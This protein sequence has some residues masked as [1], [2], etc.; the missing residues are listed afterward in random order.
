MCEVKGK[1]RSGQAEGKSHQNSHWMDKTI[2]LR[3][4]NHIGH[5][6]PESER[7]EKIFECLLKC[8][9]ASGDDKLL[10]SSESFFGDFSDGIDGLLL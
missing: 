5:D 8:L 3:G 4:Q 7:K 10:T 1:E 2:E 9:S 6:N